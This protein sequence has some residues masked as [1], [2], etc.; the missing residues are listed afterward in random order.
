MVLGLVA[1]AVIAAYLGVLWIDPIGRRW[2]AY[3]HG[4]G[5]AHQYQFYRCHGCRRMV[6]YHIIRSGGCRCFES[7]KV[8]PT[9]LSVVDKVRLL[10]VPWSVTSGAQRRDAVERMRQAAERESLERM[11]QP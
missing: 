3:W 5:E 1:A 10:Y 2:L 9:K 8:S 7:A 11:V 6:T 4:E